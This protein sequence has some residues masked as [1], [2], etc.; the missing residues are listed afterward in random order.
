MQS[1]KLVNSP[2]NGL[3]PNIRDWSTF[4]D[5]RESDD[6]SLSELWRVLHRRRWIIVAAVVLSLGLAISYCVVVKPRYTATA[7]IAIDPDKT[8][9][10][11]L[12]DLGITMPGGTD[13]QTKLETEVRI[14]QSDTLALDV[15]KKLGLVDEPLF[16][17][18]RDGKNLDNPKIRSSLLKNWQSSLTVKS[19]PKTNLIEISFRSKSADISSKAVNALLDCYI[20]RNFR[21]KYQATMQASD[22]L[23]SQLN[24]IK[25]K[26]Q[27]S[28]QKLAD[29]QKKSGILIWGNSDDSGDNIITDKL[30]EL[31]KALTAAQADRIVK[32]ARYR[33]ALT[34]NPEALADI[35]PG[36]SIQ[37]LRAQ[38]ADLNNQYAQATA[39]YGAAYPR[40]R[41]LSVQLQQ[42]QRS[43]T[44]EVKNVTD[45]LRDDYESAKRAETMLNAQMNAQ[46]AEA[47]KLN[48][49]AVQLEILK[50]EAESNRDL[51]EGLLKKLKEA[52]VV[53]GLKSTNVNVVDYADIPVGPSDPKIPL[54]LA[55]GLGGGLFLGLVG[56]FAIENLDNTLTSSEDAE[57][58]SGLP[59]LV[60]I[61]RLNVRSSRRLK[62]ASTE[63]GP[64]DIDRIALNR[65]RSHAAEA[66]RAL[67]TALLLSRSGAR[68][69]TIVVTST[70]PGEGKSTTSLNAAI[71]LAQNDSRVLL[72]DAD[73]RR[74]SLHAKLGVGG[75][76]GLSAVLAGA[77]NLED[78]IVPVEQLPN[79][80]L[81]PGGAVPP[82]PAELLASATMENV[83]KR[84]SEQ[85]DYVIIDTPPVLT[86]TDAVILASEVDCTLLVMRSG[87]T[88]KQALR[89]TRDL[90]WRANAKIAGLVVN[91]VDVDS[92]DHYYYHYGRSRYGKYYSKYYED[93]AK[94]QA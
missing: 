50:R 17:V 4:T 94:P 7:S 1:D 30:E 14:L 28:E 27:E 83:L 62:G 73:L 71:V 56:A 18:S 2:S 84:C 74:S 59:A 69:K 32:E 90:L 89:R 91:A 64:A 15:I 33:V 70:F 93:P 79:L 23:T 76:S 37:V 9:S 60:A 44:A 43:L 13:S 88:G 46:K 3:A 42:V 22:W 5:Q 65:P 45:R 75:Q 72:I 21:V 49:G 68:P 38:Q 58:Y 61:P 78:A 48:E 10:L 40:V 16:F 39:K 86:V 66:F 6:I 80:H 82:Y 51:Y 19:V 87:Q 36:S 63:I 52:G 11:N 8:D 24:D 26:S 53:A 54:I 12:Q 25:A 55:L 29:Y 85:Y 77:A 31:D 35:V 20:E 92:P 34:G 67:R 57:L 47:F 41:Q 81:L